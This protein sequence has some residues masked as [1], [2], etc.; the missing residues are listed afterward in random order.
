MVLVVLVQVRHDTRL[1]KLT[2]TLKLAPLYFVP[3][4]PNGVAVPKKKL[5]IRP[6]SIGKRTLAI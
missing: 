4:S 2:A 1:R 3:G 5:E 6:Q